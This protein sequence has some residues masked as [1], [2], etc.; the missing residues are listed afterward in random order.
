MS[1]FNTAHDF[2]AFYSNLALSR[3]VSEIFNVEKH[4]Y[5]GQRSIKVMCSI[6]NLSLKRSVF[7]TFDFEK[8]CDLE[9]RVKGH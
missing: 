3:V 7:E 4:K 1:P 8:R 9:I 6:V 2:L 5:P